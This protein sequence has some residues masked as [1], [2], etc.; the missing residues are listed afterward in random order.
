MKYIG[1]KIIHNIKF[2]DTFLKFKY[3]IS[4]MLA[5]YDILEIDWL[6]K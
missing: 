6:C 4:V 5:I 1:M 3:S 2:T